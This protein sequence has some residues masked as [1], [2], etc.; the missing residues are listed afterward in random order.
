MANARL[1]AVSLLQVP[2]EQESSAAPAES[3]TARALEQEPAPQRP[4]RRR[5]GGDGQPAEAAGPQLQ[6]GHPSAPA[7]PLRPPAQQA[8]T[9]SAGPVTAADVSGTFGTVVQAMGMH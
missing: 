2:P 5:W 4:R 3:A 6:N 1:K 7:T 8:M 9:R